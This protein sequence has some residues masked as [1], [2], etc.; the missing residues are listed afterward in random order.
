MNRLKK[1]LYDCRQAT[2][3]IEK[4]ELCPLT[5]KESIKLKLHL[6]ACSVCRI[7]QKQSVM[8]NKMIQHGFHIRQDE[9]HYMDKEFKA[10][11]QEQIIQKWTKG[12]EK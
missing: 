4:G 1:V 11:L 7:F 6:A 3:L 9:P 5:Q 8:I 12:S 2:F 10:K